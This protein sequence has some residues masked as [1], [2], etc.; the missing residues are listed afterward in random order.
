M[1][2]NHV[3]ATAGPFTG[4]S[5]VPFEGIRDSIWDEPGNSRAGDAPMSA[6]EFERRNPG[7]LGAVQNVVHREMKLAA[8]DDRKH[9][10]GNVQRLLDLHLITAYVPLVLG[11]AL[12]GI[13]QSSQ[14]Q[15]SVPRLRCFPGILR[16]INGISLHTFT[17]LLCVGAFIVS[18]RHL[19]AAL[20]L[21]GEEER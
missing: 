1:T 12:H 21:A 9:E 5:S 14:R 4:T 6:E 7:L 13:G 19:R 20:P 11:Y 17:S 2:Q 3:G 18:F 8:T 15:L 16:R 10:S